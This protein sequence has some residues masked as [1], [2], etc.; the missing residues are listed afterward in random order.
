ML[1]SGFPHGGYWDIYA[2]WNGNS[3][4]EGATSGTC[5]IYQHQAIG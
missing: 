1:P 2:Y 4:Y 3:Q 5:R